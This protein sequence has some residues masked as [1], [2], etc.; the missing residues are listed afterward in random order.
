MAIY[1]SQNFI[2]LNIININDWK[3]TKF[4]V[5]FDIDK[6]WVEIVC[7]NLLEFITVFFIKKTNVRIYVISN[8][9]AF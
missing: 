9:V 3:L 6:I 4:C 5:L 8:N 7:V 2:S 1:L